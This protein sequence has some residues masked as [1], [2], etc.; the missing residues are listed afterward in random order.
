MVTTEQSENINSLNLDGLGLALTN[1]I[2]LDRLYN[3]T[4]NFKMQVFRKSLTCPVFID[5]IMGR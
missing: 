2:I 4:G 1:G 3:L 5:Q